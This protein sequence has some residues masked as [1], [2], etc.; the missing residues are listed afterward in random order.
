[1]KKGHEIGLLICAINLIRRT[2]DSRCRPES[3]RDCE[4]LA[5]A[6]RLPANEGTSACQQVW[7]WQEPRLERPFG[8]SCRHHPQSGTKSRRADPSAGTGNVTSVAANR[9]K[10]E[11]IALPLP[12]GSIGARQNILF[13]IGI[14]DGDFY[15]FAASP[16]LIQSHSNDP[17]GADER[18]RRSLLRV[19]PEGASRM[20]LTG[21]DLQNAEGV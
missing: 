17:K 10:A 20:A 4:A 14:A 3:T 15:S 13:L 18:S 1:M 12:D 9:R 5:I 21:R 6:T 7:A 2:A 19:G 11:R 16:V 8:K